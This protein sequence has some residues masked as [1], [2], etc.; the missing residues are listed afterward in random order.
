MLWPNCSVSH[1]RE[2]HDHL[3]Q[4]RNHWNKSL[5]FLLKPKKRKSLL[6]TT[7]IKIKRQDLNCVGGDNKHCF[8]WQ[9]PA[10]KHNFTKTIKNKKSSYYNFFLNKPLHQSVGHL[11]IP[12]HRP[13]DMMRHLISGTVYSLHVHCIV[14]G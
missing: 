3:N 4:K 5:L 10:T 1:L 2:V 13:R 14:N 6:E 12:E 9:V 8:N 11:G 7:L